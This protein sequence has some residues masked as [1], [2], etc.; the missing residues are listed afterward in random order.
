MGV[1]IFNVCFFYYFCGL[2]YFV[3][4]LRLEIVFMI[5]VDKVYFS[6]FVGF[7]GCYCCR[8]VCECDS[9]FIVGGMSL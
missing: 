5:V 7:R 9:V 1:L 6:V 3:Y 2:C 4:L 8:V